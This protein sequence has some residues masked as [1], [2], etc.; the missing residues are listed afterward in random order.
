MTSKQQ[1][2]GQ[3]PPAPKKSTPFSVVL[4]NIVFDN[5][6]QT[7]LK[8]LQR[9]H[10]GIYDIARYYLQ[11]NNGA[12]IPGVRIDMKS[13]DFAKELISKK[14]IVIENRNYSIET[15]GR[16]V[17][18]MK[19]PASESIEKLS[20]DLLHNYTTIENISRFYS[21]SKDPVDCI[22]VNFKSDSNL[23]QILKDK[24]IF[25]DGKKSPIQP[26]WSL[27]QSKDTDTQSTNDAENV[28]EQPK[29]VMN[30]PRST[31]LTEQRVRKLFAEQQE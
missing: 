4:M 3:L 22:R 13:E 7:V 16:S 9:N 27:V 19:V 24:Y 8:N 10:R 28:I 12:S 26:Y 31:V 23:T 15:A 5:D 21:D 1:R 25:I 29:K 30:R 6:K 11:F 14:D 2:T 20:R 17:I 18:V